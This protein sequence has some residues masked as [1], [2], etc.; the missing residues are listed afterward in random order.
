MEALSHSIMFGFVTA[1]FT[2]KIIFSCFVVSLSKTTSKGVEMKKELVDKV[3]LSG[4]CHFHH[5]VCS[6]I[7]HYEG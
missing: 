2:L 3:R 4:F 1:E 7:L 5:H 6:E